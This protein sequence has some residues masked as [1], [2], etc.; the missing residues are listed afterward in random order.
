MDLNDNEQ[1]GTCWLILWIV[2][3]RENG[4]LLVFFD[5]SETSRS[6]VMFQ[7]DK[8]NIGEVDIRSM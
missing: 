4:P 1:V 3:R 6:L 5:F 8:E 2:L 7:R